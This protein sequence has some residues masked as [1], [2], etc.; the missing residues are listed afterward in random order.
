MSDERWQ[1]V[2]HLYHEAMARPTAARVPFLRDVCAGDDALRDEVQSLI[3]LESASTKFLERPALEAAAR[4]LSDT[5]PG[6]RPPEIPGYRIIR[7][8]G[9]GGMGVVYLAEQEFPLR[10]LV[11]LKLIRPGM[12]SRQIL[13]R[14]DTERQA[15][16]RMDHPNIAAV[17]G[18]GSTSDGR[19]YFVMEFVDGV[20]ITEYCDRAKLSTRARLGLFMQVCAAVQ[21]AHQK[22]VIHRDIKPSNVLVAEHDGHAVP[23]VIDFGTAKA[24]DPIA[25]H[26][27]TL[28]SHGT[29]IGTVEYMSPEQAGLSADIDTTTDV[30][31]LGVVL[32]ELLVG[33]LP[34]ELA[35]TDIDGYSELRRAIR[36]ADPPKPSSCIVR[37]DQS[38][39]ADSR[40]RRTDGGLLAKELKGDLDWVVLKALEKDRARRYGTVTAFA[41][42]IARFLV[43]QPVEARPP[44]SAYR[45][46]KF[47]RRHRMGLS[48]TVGAFVLLSAALFSVAS[49]YARAERARVDAEFRAYAAVVGQAD[50]ELRA[51]S[52][53]NARNRLLTI[54]PEQ[55]Q[56]EW[57]HM[58][59]AADPS[60]GTIGRS[61]ETCSDRLN[62]AYSHGI[63]HSLNSGRSVLAVRC[64]TL[65]S[66]DLATLARTS[67][68]KISPNAILAANGGDTFLAV[69]WRMGRPLAAQV[70]SRSTGRVVR[71][72][73]LLD[74][75]ALCGDLSSDGT[76]VAL[77]LRRGTFEVWNVETGERI[78]RLQTPTTTSWSST[79]IC[80]VRF[81][82]AATMVA[83]S[84]F[85]VAVWSAAT[86]DNVFQDAEVTRWRSQPVAFSADGLR[87]AI[88]RPMGKTDVID[89]RRAPKPGRNPT[90][91][92]DGLRPGEPFDPRMLESRG[93][94]TAVA[95]SGDDRYVISATGSALHVSTVA[96]DSTTLTPLST[97]T[98]HQADVVG[99]T[100]LGATGQFVSS[101]VEGV[102]KVWAIDGRLSVWRVKTPE[103]STIRLQTSP[104]LVAQARDAKGAWQER[105]LDDQSQTWHPSVAPNI[106]G[107]WTA[108][109]LPVDELKCKGSGPRRAVISAG[110]GL[111][112]YARGLCVTVQSLPDRKTLASTRFDGTVA[113]LT[114][115]RN[116]T[117]LVTTDVTNEMGR[118][119]SGSVHAWDWRSDRR[120]ASI[121]S[122][123]WPL[124]VANHDGTRV[125]IVS[126]Q[127]ATVSIWN[128]DLTR[129]L[130][131][132]TAE[133]VQGAALSADGLRLATSHTDGAIR[134]WDTAHLQQLLILRQPDT[135]PQSVYFT[136]DGRLIG[137][138]VGALTIWEIERR[139]R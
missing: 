105:S 132:I 108:E 17:F 95:F 10:R 14:F 58:F 80:H 127:T 64:A 75:E 49:M 133:Q 136:P 134:I 47:S 56:W 44:S 27:V 54:P 137:S 22:G 1:R 57:K 16:A 55:R 66:W 31:S 51:G 76:L 25:D 92:V 89:L 45:I 107:E 4:S 102:V 79:S 50:G 5:H 9:E 65:E 73:K 111:L 97:L 59:F 82:P 28:T 101:D 135:Q 61:L 18:A 30:Y 78:Q 122:S 100:A 139:N 112:A 20:P 77:G 62:P 46:R 60:I 29:A 52:A 87:L 118:T 138:E 8:L 13:A 123:T 99:L 40:P 24:T 12:D 84:F 94:T 81:N 90:K 15:L 83:T 106:V 129:E 98:G 130:G 103:G 26:R 53:A 124:V 128:G 41:D 109:L 35:S 110:G 125:A 104:M 39:P 23:K 68:R 96:A 38:Q 11:A 42:D 86:G 48:V 114:F 63:I 74:E 69:P 3:D 120:L 117:L 113:G 131:T 88:G 7:E 93:A 71:E 32:Y 115:G 33:A 36:E 21:H 34:F 67:S 19:P 37:R 6:L 2:E 116:T 85:N 119:V 126:R 72:L 70:I 91:P 121:P 43:H